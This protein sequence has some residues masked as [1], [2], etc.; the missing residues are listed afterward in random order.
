[1]TTWDEMRYGPL[2]IDLT[3]GRLVR[4][5]TIVIGLGKSE[6]AVL[7]CLMACQGGAVSHAMLTRGLANSDNLSL[8]ICRLRKR[9]VAHFGNLV[10][11]ER[12]RQYGYKLSLSGEFL[13]SSV[14]SIWRLW[15]SADTRSAISLCSARSGSL[16]TSS[17]ASAR[18]AS[19]SL[20]FL[21]ASMPRSERPDCLEP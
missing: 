12:L 21:S 18:A 10:V 1:M 4:F 14:Y 16:A 20:R 2:T 5:G 15:P 19:T 6:F 9:L 13:N 11:I 17:R 7:L 8:V 3:E